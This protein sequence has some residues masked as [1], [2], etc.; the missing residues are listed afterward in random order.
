MRKPLEV[1]ELVA[2]IDDG[3][4]VQ[5]WQLSAEGGLDEGVPLDEVIAFVIMSVEPGLRA[6]RLRLGRVYESGTFV[7]L[8]LPLR[9]ALRLIEAGI[10]ADPIEQD[11]DLW[12]DS[13]PESERAVRRVVH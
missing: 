11:G 2:M 9:D 4:W 1:S 6:G 10:G 13:L 8:E 5:L 7:P 3:D 12:F